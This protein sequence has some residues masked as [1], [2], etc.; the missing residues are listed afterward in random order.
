MAMGH[1]RIGKR[2]S[3]H[4]CKKE[5]QEPPIIDLLSTIKEA[6]HQIVVAVAAKA[7]TH[8][9]I[10]IASSMV[11][12]LTITQKIAPYFL[13]SKIKMDQESNQPSQQMAPRK[14]NH[15]MQWAP[16]H[17]QYSPS[18]PSHFLSQVYQTVKPKLQPITNHTTTPQPTTHNLYQLHK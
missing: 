8:S 17:Q 15:T 7:H 4:L 10:H 6:A 14:V 12:K 5:T 2:I 18:Y 13:K 9:D 1:Q 16:H 11:G 3:G